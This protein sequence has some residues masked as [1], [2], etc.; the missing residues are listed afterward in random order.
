MD[1]A[2]FVGRGG[3]NDDDGK[4][5]RSVNVGMVALLASWMVPSGRIPAG[6]TSE[7]CAGLQG[8]F[9]SEAAPMNE[10]VTVDGGARATKGRIG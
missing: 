5:K 9:R 4:P 8:A 1:S 6:G 7:G 2:D 3:G 10:R